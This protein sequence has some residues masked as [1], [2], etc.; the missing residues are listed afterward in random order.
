MK[1][2]SAVFALSGLLLFPMIS[3]R[4]GMSAGSLPRLTAVANYTFHSLCDNVQNPD[5]FFNE[6]DVSQIVNA[7][8]NDMVMYLHGNG[9]DDS[10]NQN[11]EKSCSSKNRL[12]VSRRRGRLQVQEKTFGETSAV[13]QASLK[14]KQFES[15]VR[16]FDEVFQNMTYAISEK[17][18]RQCSTAG[19]AYYSA[20]GL[21]RNFETASYYGVGRPVLQSF[22][23]QIREI[24]AELGCHFNDLFLIETQ[25][26]TDN[27]KIW[28]ETFQNER[29][30]C[31]DIG[32]RTSATMTEDQGDS[33]VELR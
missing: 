12:R 27:A 11:E 28:I 9:P 1:T 33:S 19:Y 26:A 30:P 14:C 10:R 21:Q 29:N 4:T 7:F 32:K 6:L 15:D 25:R 20:S 13:S 2:L 18:Y 3:A 24:Q 5:L 23:V 22:Y 17:C 8:V 31:R 16:L